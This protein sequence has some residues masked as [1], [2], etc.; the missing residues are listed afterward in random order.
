LL[1]LVYEREYNR[2]GEGKFDMSTQQSPSKGNKASSKGSNLSDTPRETNDPAT[3]EYSRLMKPDEYRE[4]VRQTVSGQI[5][6]RMTAIFSAV[7]FAAIVAMFTYVSNVSNSTIEGKIATE[8]NNLNQAVDRKLPIVV[9]QELTD[10]IKKNELVPRITKEAVDKL[11]QNKG[12][13]TALQNLIINQSQQ[14]LSNQDPSQASLRAVALQQILLFGAED[15]KVEAITNVMLDD[16][17]GDHEFSLALQNY[18][19]H[20][21][22]SNSDQRLALYNILGR[23]ALR[24]ANF[25]PDSW[26]AVGKVLKTDREIV[27]ACGWLRNAVTPLDKKYSIDSIR[28]IVEHIAKIGGLAA[29]EQ[30]VGWLESNDLELKG[31]GQDALTGC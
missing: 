19:A 26:H 21:S 6:G 15:Q 16:S 17:S 14:I 29:G 4:W 12:V 23:A 3:G 7:G 31:L 30:F 10:Q 24:D 28:I 5:W 9:A 2:F 20:Q 18:P 13:E 8:A 11:T 22:K 25:T 1:L 27:E